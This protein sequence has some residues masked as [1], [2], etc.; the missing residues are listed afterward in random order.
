MLA[1]LGTDLRVLLDSLD[2]AVDGAY[3]ASQ[4]PFRARFYPY[5]WLLIDEGCLSVSQF[6]ARLGFS[7]PAVTQTL[8]LMR[9]AD[10]VELAPSADKRER[11][12]RLTGKSEAMRSDLQ[13]IWKAVELAAARLDRSLP[14][15]LAETVRAAL[16]QLSKV[17]FSQ[18]INEELKR[19][20]EMRGHDGDSPG[21]AV[22]RAS[23]SADRPG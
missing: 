12:Y 9:A 7:Q 15:P 19:A 16:T 21:R 10:L 8:A 5:L 6:A 17:P 22:G 3:A 11:R 18:M 23:A 13:R 14:A 4:V 2:S 1:S 20:D